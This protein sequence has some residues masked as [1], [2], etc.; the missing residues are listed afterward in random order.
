PENARP[1]ARAAR[2]LEVSPRSRRNGTRAAHRQR[3]QKRHPA[4]DRWRRGTPAAAFAQRLE[5]VSGECSRRATSVRAGAQ[6][7]TR[8]LE[9]P[10]PLAADAGSRAGTE[11]QNAGGHS[12]SATLAARDEWRW[13]DGP[14]VPFVSVARS[15]R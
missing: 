3:G 8:N 7:A 12:R 13:C 2:S 1:R 10:D 9:L 4:F 15:L 14:D 5:E 11:Y 6:G